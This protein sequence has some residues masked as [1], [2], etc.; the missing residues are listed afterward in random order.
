MLPDWSRLLVFFHVHRTG[1]VTAAARELHVT[2][3]AV[4]QSL[5]KLEQA[6]GAQLFVRRHRRLVPA[7]AATRLSAIVAPC[8]LALEGGVTEIHRAQHEL[9]GVLRLGAPVELGAHR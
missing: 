4:S 5:A 9:A 3:S 7:P 8:A 2:Q 6:L 1:S